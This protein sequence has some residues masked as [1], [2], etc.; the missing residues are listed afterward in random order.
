MY[1]AG[2]SCQLLDAFAPVLSLVP[3]ASMA[4]RRLLLH[5]LACP[6]QHCVNACLMKCC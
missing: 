2:L 4:P 6:G 5:L 1:M 3:A